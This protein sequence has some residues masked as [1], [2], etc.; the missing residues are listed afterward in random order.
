M[1]K[2]E[3]KNI[4]TTMWPFFIVFITIMFF[5]L[6]LIINP[7]EKESNAS[8]KLQNSNQ[9]VRSIKFK[10][11]QTIGEKYLVNPFDLY[12][13]SKN[14]IFVADQSSEFPIL[15]FSSNGTLKY[16][17]GKRGRGPGEIE[18]LFYILGAH[19]KEI[20]ILNLTQ[21]KIQIFHYTGTLVSE[22]HIPFSLGGTL[23]RG[24]ITIITGGNK[25]LI[26][27]LKLI[28][29]NLKYEM[30]KQWDFPLDNLLDIKSFENCQKNPLL[31]QGKIVSDENNNV[32]LGFSFSSIILGI[33]HEGDYIFSNALPYK[34]SFPNFSKYSEKYEYTSPPAN[35]F[36][37]ITI[38]LA[39]DS[40]YLYRVYLG[41]RTDQIKN[42]MVLMKKDLSQGTVLD[43]YNKQTGDY[44]FSTMLPA[45]A[46]ALWV[47]TDRVYILTTF[48]KIGVHIYKKPQEFYSL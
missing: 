39:I 40:L 7:H 25:N 11:L 29:S 18:K 36:P 38:D 6:L 34:V 9:I 37:R 42:P 28:K 47:N 21:L 26:S 17:I 46:K 13:D 19:K 44:L 31:K 16:R 2:T 24:S 23:K 5:L 8:E 4:Y 33:S 45:P 12:V 1:S 35:L 15:G 30:I 43:V 32:F 14:N 27:S 20:Y 22:F 48:P 3:K 41:F 10:K